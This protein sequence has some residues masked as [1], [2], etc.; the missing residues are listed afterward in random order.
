MPCVG[1]ITGI[2][3]VN[4][5]AL[6][7]QSRRDPVCNVLRLCGRDTYILINRQVRSEAVTQKQT[8]RFKTY[9]LLY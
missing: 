4:A 7:Y 6:T 2:S 9:L 1:G 5:M 8:I 3:V